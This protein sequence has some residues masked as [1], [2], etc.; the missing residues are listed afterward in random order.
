MARIQRSTAKGPDVWVLPM[1]AGSAPERKAVPYLRSPSGEDYARF[2]PDVRFVAY[3]SDESGS[4]ELYLRPF[5][6]ADPEASGSGGGKVRIS[7]GGI[8]GAPRWEPDGKGLTYFAPDSK[9]WMVDL[10]TSPTLRV[11]APRLLGQFPRSNVASTPDN[12][13][14]LVDL[15][16]TN[17]QPSA[18]VVLH[19]QAALKR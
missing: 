9:R 15:P 3:T 6:P 17:K 8:E 13:R 7:Q 10:T 5:D 12:Q 16:A 18:A 14:V 19:W 1:T 11:S 4:W 2:S